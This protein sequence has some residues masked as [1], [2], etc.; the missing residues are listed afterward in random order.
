MGSIT[1][2]ENRIRIP[3][4]L[5]IHLNFAELDDIAIELSCRRPT[6][7]LSKSSDA[8]VRQLVS[9]N[10]FCKHGSPHRFELFP[11]CT[12]PD[13]QFCTPSRKRVEAGNLLCKYD[14]ISQWKRDDARVQSNPARYGG[15]HRQGDQWVK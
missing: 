15:D 1:S 6:K 3:A 8:L 7:Q 12:H 13:A 2:Y 11:V 14:D 9:V 4:W 5:W 10:F